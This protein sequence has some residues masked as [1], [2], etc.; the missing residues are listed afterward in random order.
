MTLFIIFCCEDGI[1][2]GSDAIQVSGTKVYKAD[3][4][5]HKFGLLFGVC[6]YI[7]VLHELLFKIESLE[8]KPSTLYGFKKAIEDILSHIGKDYNL[9][10]ETTIY[11]LGLEKITSGKAMCFE[12]ISKYGS[13]VEIYAC[14]GSGC[15][16]PFSIIDL[17]EGENTCE[18]NAKRAAFCIYWSSNIGDFSVGGKPKI[19][20]MKDNNPEPV[21]LDEIVIKKIEK[22][23]QDA[24]ASLREN[25]VCYLE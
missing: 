16:I 1:V 21:Y 18:Y 10:E 19:V 2:M 14:S 9:D 6:G 20:I 13:L 24:K 3:K 11:V 7:N 4:I 12:V 8:Q 22:N 5:I 23:V 25:I 17:T 15:D